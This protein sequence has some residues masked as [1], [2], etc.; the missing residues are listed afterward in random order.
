MPKREIYIAGDYD[1]CFDILFKE[2]LNKII[3]EIVIKYYPLI[4]WGLAKKMLLQFSEEYEAWSSSLAASSMSK[5]ERIKTGIDDFLK[6]SCMRF[7]Y[8]ALNAMAIFLEIKKELLDR[9]KEITT[10]KKEGE[11]VEV[12]LLI[13]SARQSEELEQEG[14]QLNN[15][16]HCKEN[17]EKFVESKKNNHVKW[18]FKGQYFNSDNKKDDSFKTGLL[19]KQLTFI[20]NSL[21]EGNSAEFY[22]FDDRHDIL[23]V[24]IKHFLKE[25][26]VKNDIKNIDHIVLHRFNWFDQF[27]WKLMGMQD[28]FFY[29]FPSIMYTIIPGLKKFEK[30][31]DWVEA[32]EGFSESYFPVAQQSDSPDKLSASEAKKNKCSPKLEII[33]SKRRRL[34]FYSNHG[35]SRIIEVALPEK[36]SLTV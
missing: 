33:P 29:E 34:S 17:F 2:I 25:E 26:N 16:G 11:E 4:L 30:S 7:S 28:E 20:N 1:G 13:G 35:Q 14:I 27:Y 10:P 18:R 32:K 36:R 22:F 12:I 24:L 5:K 8:Q 6:K 31:A 19:G 3:D 21:K 15:N 9:L 23:D